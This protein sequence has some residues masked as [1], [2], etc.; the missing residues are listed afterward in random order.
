[1]FKKVMALIA[2]G[3]LLAVCMCGCEQKDSGHSSDSGVLGVG[4]DYG[5]K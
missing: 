1:M 3:L 2:A 4:V 5:R